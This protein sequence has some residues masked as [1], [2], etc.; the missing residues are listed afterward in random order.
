MFVV[1]AILV[2]EMLEYNLYF[3]EACGR[4]YRH[5][6]NLT[7][8]QTYECGKQPQFHCQFCNYSTKLKRSLKRHTLNKHLDQVTATSGDQSLGSTPIQNLMLVH[9][10]T[11]RSKS[12][13]FSLCLVQTNQYLMLTLNFGFCKP[14]YL[15]L[16]QPCHYNY[17][18]MST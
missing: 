16:I 11:W 9:L 15:V 7:Q 8:H 13:S 17:Y 12:M 6:G 3:C 1:G 5:K 2:S 18:A 4:K 10:S 14:T